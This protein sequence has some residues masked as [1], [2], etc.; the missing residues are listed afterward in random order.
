[1][2][3]C[4]DGWMYVCMDVCMYMYVCICMYMCMYV[5]MYVCTH[6]V[7]RYANSKKLYT[8]KMTK[9]CHLPN[10]H[11]DP[12]LHSLA[13]AGTDTNNQPQSK[14]SLLSAVLQ[15]EQIIIYC[16]WFKQD[17]H[18]IVLLNV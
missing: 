7:H 4:M 6:N 16:H 3:V 1:M 2:Y 10:S 18:R 13:L 8:L 11:S 17:I 14:W 12:S 5:C 15:C 9:L